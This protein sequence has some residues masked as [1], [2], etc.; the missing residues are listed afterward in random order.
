MKKKKNSKSYG[1]EESDFQ[2]CHICHLKHVFFNKNLS[3]WKETG[4]YGPYEKL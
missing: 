3:A 2:N 1:V 4:N